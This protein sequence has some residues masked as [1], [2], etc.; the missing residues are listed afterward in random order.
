MAVGGLFALFDDIALLM[1][2]A[3]G[4]TGDDLAVSAGQCHG[5]PAHREIPALWRITKGSLVNKAALVVILLAIDYFLPALATVLL[6]LG[7]CYIA[8]EAGEKVFDW[9][10]IGE[11]EGEHEVNTQTEDQMVKGALRTDIV[12]SA[13]IMIIS[14][15]SIPAGATLEYKALTLSIVAILIT[16]IVYGFVT[17]LVRMDDMGLAL[18]KSPRAFVSGFGKG[19]ATAAP[20]MMQWIGVIGTIAI[21]MVA[22]GIYRHTFHLDSFVGVLT[23]LPEIIGDMSVGFVAG[24]VLAGV[25]TIYHKLSHK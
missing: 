19:M 13:E 1:K 23:A 8:F 17:F 20:T 24:V 14:L 16:L 12:L 18:M 15:T 6:I 22:G 4:V 11:P 2:K 3:A 5:L 9:L 21:F 25:V 10:G 7:A